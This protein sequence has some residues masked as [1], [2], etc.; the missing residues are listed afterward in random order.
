MATNRNLNL[1]YNLEAFE[2]KRQRSK[3]NIIRL[4]SRKARVK[5]KLRLQKLFLMSAALSVTVAAMGV[6]VLMFGQATLNELTNETAKL[7]KNLKE[8]ESIH[9]QLS[10]KIKTLELSRKENAKN[11]EYIETVSIS[12]GDKA[13]LTD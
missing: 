4:P 11:S 2:P 1:A 7:T 3:E 8:A 6:S 12:R 9:T 10:M 5:A 13:F